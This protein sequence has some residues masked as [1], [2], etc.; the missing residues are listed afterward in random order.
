MESTVTTFKRPQ[1]MYLTGCNNWSL[2][3]R[4]HEGRRYYAHDWV[5]HVLDA[6]DNPPA[7]DKS[8]NGAS[9]SDSVSE[10]CTFTDSCIL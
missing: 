8:D 3:K 7:V 1:T 6:V 9:S 5:E 4:R 2:S 10:Q